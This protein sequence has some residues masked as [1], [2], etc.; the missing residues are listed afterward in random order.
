MEAAGGAKK[1]AQRRGAGPNAQSRRAKLATA[2]VAP[3]AF[4]PA[5]PPSIFSRSTL[6]S[7]HRIVR[8][9]LYAVSATSSSQAASS[10][11]ASDGAPP[12]GSGRESTDIVGRTETRANPQLSDVR[13]VTARTRGAGGTGERPDTRAKRD[14]KKGSESVC[15]ASF[16][17]FCFF[18]TRNEPLSP[19]PHFFF[20]FGATI[21]PQS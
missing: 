2:R 3:L 6:S 12:M 10:A 15:E 18:S 21:Q 9:S 11:C 13:A 20:C 7:T 1:G 16:R 14:G 19:R 5:S 8:R 17:E 4:P